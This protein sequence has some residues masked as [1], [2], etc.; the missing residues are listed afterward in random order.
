[1]KPSLPE[2]IYSSQDIAGLLAEVQSYRK[3]ISARDIAKRSNAK[4]AD[5]QPELSTAAGELLRSW[6][7]NG[8][9]SMQKLEE[10]ITWLDKLTT[11]APTITIT[12]AA[13]A[14]HTIKDQL[15]KWCRTNLSD[16]MV[17]NFRFNSTLLGGMVVQCGS[18]IYDWS[19]RRQLMNSR[20]K[21][22]EVLRRV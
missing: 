17:I 21:F 1:M 19:F 8:Q 3:W 14:T 18:H 7:D 5:E 2:N 20:D 12:L 13:P 11:D 4:S 22:P 16:S 6:S 10:L 15:A 9:L